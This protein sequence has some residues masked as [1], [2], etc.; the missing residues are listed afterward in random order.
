MNKKQLLLTIAALGALCVPVQA[1]T[2]AGQMPWAQQDAF[3]GLNKG[4][5]TATG[6]GAV[7]LAAA[8]VMLAMPSVR[9][10]AR[11]AIKAQ[12]NQTKFEP[13]TT[14]DYIAAG[15]IGTL[16]LAGVAA[17]ISTPFLGKKAGAASASG[18]AKGSTEEDNIDDLA[19]IAMLNKFKLTRIEPDLSSED[20]ERD[21]Q[22]EKFFNAIKAADAARA[23]AGDKYYSTE[24]LELYDNVGKGTGRTFAKAKEDRAAAAKEDRAAATKV[25]KIARGYLA[26]KTLPKLKSGDTT[27]EETDRLSKKPM[28]KEEALTFAR[29]YD[30]KKDQTEKAEAKKGRRRATA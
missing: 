5:A 1:A 26:R 12:K 14:S 15:L 25:T 24:A 8:A 23:Q 13:T 10:S 9:N 6:V 17:L 30:F 21:A 19:E 11:R 7:S 3:W 16:T 20:P 22:N 2:E 29:S 28:T 18:A 27:Q 4:Q